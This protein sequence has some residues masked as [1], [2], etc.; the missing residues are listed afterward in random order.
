MQKQ[1]PGNTQAVGNCAARRHSFAAKPLPHPSRPRSGWY[2]FAAKPVHQNF[3]H[4][5]RD[6]GYEPGDKKAT[7]HASMKACLQLHATALPL[8]S[9]LCKVGTTHIP[10]FTPAPAT[11]QPKASCFV[12]VLGEIHSDTEEGINSLPQRYTRCKSK[13]PQPRNTRS[14][15][16]VLSSA[17]HWKTFQILLANWF[18]SAACIV[19]ASLM[20][21][22]AG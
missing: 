18:A 3:K 19:A 8:R 21:M 11:Q 12:E 20:H 2:G 10:S 15:A 13:N 4:R 22:R 5:H 14:Q 6:G 9:K 17:Q 7:R 16:S 1:K